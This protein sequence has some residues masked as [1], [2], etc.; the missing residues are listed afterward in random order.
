MG[1][2]QQP[3]AD[4]IAEPKKRRRVGF[5]NI[6]DAGVEAKE[7][8]KIYLVSRKEEVDSADSF[9]IDPIDLSSFFDEDGKIYGYQGLKITIWVSCIS[10]HAY[11]DIT[12]QSTADGGKGITDLKAA[13]QRI[14]AETIIENKDDFVQTFSTETNLIRSII[15]SG[16]ILK[17]KASNGHINNSN[18][19]LEAANSDV[20]VVRMVV[21]STAAGH[22]YSCLIPLV[23]LLVDGSS[24]IDVI[25]PRWELYV[26]IQKKPD[27]QGEIQCRLLGFTAI[28]RFFHYP[29]SSRLR[30]SQILVL[31]PY[32][33]KG[34]GRYLLEVLNNVAVSEDVYDL[35]V[36]EPLDYFQHVRTCVDIPRLLVFDPIQHA[37]SSVVSR[38]KEGKLSKKIHIPRF[39]PPPSVIDDVRKSLKINK[40]QFLK[41]WE[42][43]IYLALD[44]VDKYMED[45]VSVISKR[46]KDDIIGKDSGTAGKRLIE[47]PGDYDQEMSFVMCRSQAGEASSVQMDENETTQEEQLRQ[48]VDERVK[49]IKLIAQKVS[50]H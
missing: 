23:L 20:E 22:L 45:Y 4:P 43:L 38:M 8:I 42:V 49:E 37:V 3:T 24:P 50:L 46:V 31:P 17:Y 40:K 1:Q 26:L 29:E 30:L 47:V 44:P 32:Q 11:A 7:C 33:H 35:T 5:S 13:L 39:M 48:L 25:D 18:S 9:C 34:Y 14:F 41:C 27:Q 21:G 2:K 19:H 15:S 16:E 10:F 12:F 28:Y 36:E 6:A